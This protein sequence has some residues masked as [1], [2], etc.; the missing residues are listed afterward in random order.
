MKVNSPDG[1]IQLVTG[2]GP[3]RARL[4]SRLGITAIRDALLYLPFRYEDRSH[5]KAF[6]ELLPGTVETVA[7]TVVACNAARRRGRGVSVLEVILHDGA[8]YLKIKWFNQSFLQKSIA[9]GKTMVVS[10]MVKKNTRD[11]PPLE[12]DN[13]EYE[14]LADDADSLI[15]TGRVV[16]VYRVTGGISQKQ[17]RKLMFALVKE[18]ASGMEDPLPQEIIA[19][20]ELPGL[21]ESIR[22]LHFPGSAEDITELNSGRSR[23]HRRLA[24]DELFYF[25]LGLAV[26]K[27][28][29]FRES[30]IAFRPKGTLKSDFLKLLPFTLTEA[31]KQVMEQI[32]TDMS[33]P[34]PMNRLVQGDVGC[35]KTVVAFAAMMDA[36]ES[37][38]QAALM[39]PTEI[40][41]EQHYLNMHRMI[42]K[43]GLAV[44]LRTGGGGSRNNGHAG[45]GTADIVIG[46]HALIQEKITFRRLGLVVI[47]EQHKFGVMQRGLLRKK[48]LAPDV[49]VMTATPIPRSLAL[50][51]YGDL[52]CSVIQ[53]LPPGRE[54]VI[55]SWVDSGKKEEIYAL[56]QQEIGQG[57][58]A[59]V[60]YPAIEESETSELRSA[61]QG[62]EA[63]ERKF[64]EYRIGLLHGRMKP[65]ERELVMDRFKRGEIDLLVSTTVIEVGVDV[66]NATV[67]LVVHAER[68]G[69]SQLHQ[70]RGRVGRGTD[71][72]R[73][74][75]IAYEPVGEDARRRLDVMVRTNDGFM[76]AEEDLG[77]R[78]PGEFFGTRQ[79]GMPDLR[80]ADLRRDAVILAAARQEAFDLISRDGELRKYPFLKHQ[81]DVFWKGRADLFKT[82]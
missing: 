51:L 17:F 31:Q 53:E 79:A 57:R 7:G 26:L 64:P 25:T 59:Y 44:E 78:G 8:G 45:E 68:F 16:P 13:P 39:A 22:E 11:M 24:F 36:V 60:V 5:L 20:H 62:K 14:F 50:T 37:G 58:Q 61:V 43:L 69:L 21:A 28:R 56:L 66:P 49:L 35:G 82:G 63:F 34:H 6:H 75:L 55:T 74:L 12:M 72:A 80:N 77:I 52:D 3:Q 81:L 42:D 73:C 1:S 2:V 15:H 67:M 71:S 9:M 19:R 65:G 46:T 33:E 48:G 4:L 38:Y 47:D 70:L 27:R 76:I 30:G 40:L 54:P 41:A 10:G 32:S 29:G 18:H 23:H